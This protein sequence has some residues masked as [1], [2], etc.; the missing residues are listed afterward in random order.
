M[1]VLIVFDT[2]EGHTK[3]VVEQV[4]DTFT[5]MGE[6]A[7]LY[8]SSR[9]SKSLEVTTHDAIVVAG[10]IHQGRHQDSIGDFVRAH[11]SELEALPTA[12]LSVSLSAAF[13]DGL[14]EAHSYVEQFL[15]KSGWQPSRIHL[16]AGALKHSEY[17]YFKEQFVRYVVLQDRNVA[18]GQEDLEF[19]DWDALKEFTTSFVATIKQYE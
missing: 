18:V 12:F 19:T 17:D 14:Q 8:E 1:N 2:T 5:E 4:R 9:Q 10:S 3:K 7:E 6:E 13:E 11:L 15:I 16:V